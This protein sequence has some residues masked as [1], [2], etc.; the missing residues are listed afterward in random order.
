MKAVAY[1]RVSTNKE[2]Q[3][4]SLES[5]EAFFLEYAKRNKYHLTKIYADEGKS[6]T[7]MKNR[8]QL[9]RLL[10][11]AQCHSFEVV[12]IKDVS[13]LARNTVDFLT[14]IRKMKAL[15]ITVIFVNSDQTSSDSSEF[16]LTMLSAI[17]QE[18][19]SNTSKR[20][21][22]GKKQ[23]AEKGRVPNLIYGYDKIPDDYFHL[24]INEKEA[25]V[26]RDIFRRYLEGQGE[27]TIA[28]ELNRAGLKTKRGCNWS[29]NAVARILSNEIYIGRVVNGKQEVAD[30]LTGKRRDKGKEKWLVT[31]KPELRLVD[32]V[33][34]RRVQALIAQKRDTFQHSGERS[35]RKNI[36]SKLI[37]CTCCGKS[38]RRTV[39]NF[40]TPYV[41]WICTGRSLNGV[42]TCPN[43]T[44]LDEK[45]L[46]D[47]IRGYFRRILS[48]KPKVIRGI[49]AEFNRQYQTKDQNLVSERDLSS[50]L[51]KARK[52]KQKYL[53]LYDNEII[54]M[55][56]LRAKAADLNATISRLEE[57]LRLV[58][59]HI[60][61]SD[62][63]E[64]GLEETFRDIDTVLNADVITNDLLHRVLDSIQVDE[65]GN[66]DI[67]LKVLKEIG[68]PESVQ[69]SDSR[70]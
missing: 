63:L 28:V 56:E 17:A 41:K 20:V 52:S 48:D 47:S 43:R 36:F 38:F 49:V 66:V 53:D 62:L 19:S 25:A 22:F 31:E 34:F 24:D 1:C 70:T 69:L 55:E 54:T 13:R 57:E 51:A 6:G 29:Q 61:K 65:K 40:K 39:R 4:D 42:D 10:S 21:K 64:S 44:I 12:L 67:Y 50:Q 11:D 3:L 16:M 33:T 30:F 23:N 18:E 2:E 37:K 26:V 7:K 9:L 8:T 59:N 14:S 58:K 15:G 5:Q 45:E 32:D 68:L 60:S 46:L 35:S 27:T